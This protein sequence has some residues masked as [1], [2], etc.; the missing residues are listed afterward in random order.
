MRRVRFA[1]YPV[2]ATQ[3]V[4]R[5]TIISL[6]APAAGQL[7]P[8][9]FWKVCNFRARK[10]PISGATTTAENFAAAISTALEFAVPTV[11]TPDAHAALASFGF[12]FS[13]AFPR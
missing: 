6:L 3:D 11:G 5:G 10:V 9:P 12:W 4:S 2:P 1:P 7:P 13:L 8:A